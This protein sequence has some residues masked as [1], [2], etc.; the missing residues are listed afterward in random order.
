ML[1]G[2]IRDITD[3]HAIQMQLKEA[4]ETAGRANQAKSRFPCEREP[5]SASTAADSRA[6]EWSAAPNGPGP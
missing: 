3:P 6:A 4:R 1:T 5:G 2:A